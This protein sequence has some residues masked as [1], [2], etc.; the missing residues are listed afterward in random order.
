MVW[1]AWFGGVSSE[2]FVLKRNLQECPLSFWVAKIF[3]KPKQ[4][5][6]LLSWMQ[7][8]QSWNFSNGAFYDLKCF[9]QWICDLKRK[10]RLCAELFQVHFWPY[11]FVRN[12]KHI[13]K[14]S[15][16]RVVAWWLFQFNH[17]P[18]NFCYLFIRFLCQNLTIEISL[19]WHLRKQA[20]R[21]PYLV[22]R[23]S[24]RLWLKRWWWG[25]LGSS[26]PP[27]FGVSMVNY[28]SWQI[29]SFK[30]RILSSVG[31]KLVWE[32]CRMNPK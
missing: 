19:S 11:Y 21:A 5:C 31:R 24:S 15:L 9:Q 2:S 3:R 8:R 6:F 32:P 14:F 27:S 1:V 26:F 18:H 7:Q 10:F 4:E 28:L 22:I 17:E 25:W 30:F 29:L 20:E 16:D 12:L 23:H 13:E